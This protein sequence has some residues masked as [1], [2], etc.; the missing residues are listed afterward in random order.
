MWPVFGSQIGT[1]GFKSIA[2]SRG[3]L[4]AVR[5]QAAKFERRRSG[6]SDRAHF[7]HDGRT[8]TISEAIASH[9]GQAS[10]AA[11][12][13]ASLGSSDL[14]ALMGFLSSI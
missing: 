5:R 9:G 13:F 14:Q 6:A 8:Q 12:N 4:C 2:S 7:L 11:A 10:G 1:V 3:A